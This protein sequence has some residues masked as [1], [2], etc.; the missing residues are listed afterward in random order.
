MR[1]IAA[2]A[3]TLDLIDACPNCTVVISQGVKAGSS[4]TA[5][6]PTAT[7]MQI[8]RQQRNIQRLLDHAD[9]LERWVFWAEDVPEVPPKLLTAEKSEAQ[10]KRARAAAL[11]ARTGGRDEEKD[12]RDMTVRE[13]ARPQCPDT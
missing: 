7:S 13:H 3:A 5:A 11:T 4:L 1:V 2:A 8:A 12:L 10:K 9:F 6:E